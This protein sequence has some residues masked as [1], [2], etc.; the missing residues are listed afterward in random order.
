MMLS[1]Q[2]HNHTKH[3]FDS[4]KTRKLLKLWSPT[5]FPPTTLFSVATKIKNG[6]KMKMKNLWV[7]KKT[8]DKDEDSSEF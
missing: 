7:Q 3:T 5:I 1:K 8:E 6:L 4:G 2:D